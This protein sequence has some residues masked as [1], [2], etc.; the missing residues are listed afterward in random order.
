MGRAGRRERLKGERA[1][2]QAE[3]GNRLAT[4]LA[5]SSRLR[6]VGGL[7][8]AAGLTSLFSRHDDCA[9]ALKR[10]HTIECR[11]CIARARS[12]P[13]S[14]VQE[15]G[16]NPRGPRRH[17]GYIPSATVAGAVFLPP[18]RQDVDLPSQHRTDGFLASASGL[19]AA[20]P[21]PDDGRLSGREGKRLGVDCGFWRLDTNRQ[22]CKPVM[23]PESAAVLQISSDD[24]LPS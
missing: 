19:L 7:S 16:K 18:S 5:K 11:R 13:S 17:R 1:G 23:H 12:S 20:L 21:T 10:E 15:R 14:Q 24:S 6:C 9:G 3:T 2:G 8:L 4:R 22:V